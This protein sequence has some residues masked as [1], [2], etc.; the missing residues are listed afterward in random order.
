M[1]DY[2]FATPSFWTGIAR[3]LDLG[4]TFDS[5]NESPT[6]TMADRRAMR[7]DWLAVGKE[8]EVAMKCADEEVG[9]GPSD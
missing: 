2:L 4:G 6:P 9:D 8:L 5:Y 3:V 1:S 7:L